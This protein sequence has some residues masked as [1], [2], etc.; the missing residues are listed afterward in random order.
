MTC[1]FNL[2]GVSFGFIPNLDDI[3]YGENKDI[4]GYI[5]DWGNMHRAM[6]VMYRPIKQKLKGKYLIE[7]YN[8]SHIYA[9]TMKQMPLS[10]VMGSIVFF[11][12]LTN[13][14]LSCIPN[15]LENQLKTE[16]MNGVVSQENG[17]VIQNYIHSLKGTLLDLE[18]LLA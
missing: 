3:S 1:Q 6:A 14:L 13:E 10:I 8:G 16:Q 5:N 11:Y 2:N 4:T 12:N 7:D 17:A 18:R 9:E 15:Y